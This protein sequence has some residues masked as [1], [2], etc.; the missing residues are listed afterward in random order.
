MFAHC[1]ELLHYLYKEKRCNLNIKTDAFILLAIYFLLIFY[2]YLFDNFNLRHICYNFKHFNILFP[3]Q[4]F[5]E[6]QISKK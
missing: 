3:K 2:G 6:K 4:Y 1:N 5:K